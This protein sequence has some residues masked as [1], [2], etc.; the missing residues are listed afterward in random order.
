MGCE[1]MV[2]MNKCGGGWRDGIHSIT[3]PSSSLL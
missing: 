1:R 3:S 2:K